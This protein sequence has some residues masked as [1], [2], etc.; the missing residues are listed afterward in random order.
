VT[1]SN[2]IVEVRDCW[3][4]ASG[5][6]LENGLW[7]L[8]F[9]L[10]ALTTLDQELRQLDS[11]YEVYSFHFRLQVNDGA[12]FSPAHLETDW[13]IRNWGPLHAGLD[14]FMF[15]HRVHQTPPQPRETHGDNTFTIRM[16]QPL[17]RRRNFLPML[18]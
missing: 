12:A 4:A 5:R 11:G 6:A 1:V 18:Q 13:L 7:P 15:A 8:R 3:A 10:E 16:R 2:V 17:F 14:V 9:S